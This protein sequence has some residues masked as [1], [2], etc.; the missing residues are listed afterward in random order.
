MG[1]RNAGLTLLGTDFFER[2]LKALSPQR[3]YVPSIC[4]TCKH[5]GGEASATVYV[6][7]ANLGVHSIRGGLNV[8]PDRGHAA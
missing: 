3:L 8:E 5:D 7:S 2:H 4:S 1:H 6:V